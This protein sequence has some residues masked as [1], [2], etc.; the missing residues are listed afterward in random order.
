MT[1]DRARVRAIL[2][3]LAA[4]APGRSVELRVP[5]FGAVQIIEGP[6]HR[7]GTPKATVEMSPATL[8]DLARGTLTWTDAVASGAVLASGERTDLGHLFPLP[9]D[10]VGT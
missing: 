2:A 10:T 4:A 3:A 6:A 7:R 5:P 8:T 1:D 9:A